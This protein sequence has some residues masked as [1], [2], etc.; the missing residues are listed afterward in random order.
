MRLLPLAPSVVPPSHAQTCARKSQLDVGG[1]EKRHALATKD[2]NIEA[3]T[4]PDAHGKYQDQKNAAPEGT[5]IEKE[6]GR[7]LSKDCID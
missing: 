1:D 7:K 2:F 5:V 6:N 3:T 4:I